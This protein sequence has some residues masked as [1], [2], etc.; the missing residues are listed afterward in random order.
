MGTANPLV[1]PTG[2]AEVTHRFSLAGDPEVMTWSHGVAG[3]TDS[4]SL[5]D[6]V[7]TWTGLYAAGP[8]GALCS[9]YTYLGATGRT[10]PAGSNLVFDLSESI[11]GTGGADSIPQNCALIIRKRTATGGRANSGRIFQPGMVAP[12]EVDNAGNIA[13]ASVTS[14][15]AT[16]A[17]FLSDGA[18]STFDMV[19]LHS[20]FVRDPADPP[21]ATTMM[22]NPHTTPSI[23][24]ALTVEPIIA[25]QRRRLR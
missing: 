15:Q 9:A 11:P 18:A 17:T 21:P 3:V 7:G 6:A 25:T 24:T 4:V 1:I 10:D 20:K 14:L 13:G 22:A 12:D 19:L 16:W 23:V 2:Y 5:G 8:L